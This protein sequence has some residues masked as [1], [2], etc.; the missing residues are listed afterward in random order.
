MIQDENIVVD[1]E[2]NRRRFMQTA[3]AASTAMVGLDNLNSMS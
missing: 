3:G 2:Q 1:R